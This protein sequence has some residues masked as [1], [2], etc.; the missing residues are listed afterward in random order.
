LNS[1]LLLN[2]NIIDFRKETSDLKG[3]YIL[4]N[5]FGKE[6]TRKIS[7]NFE[8]D[9]G[10]WLVYR[11][12]SAEESA[13]LKRENGDRRI[14]ILLQNYMTIEY[15]RSHASSNIDASCFYIVGQGEGLKTMAA[16]AERMSTKNV[17][18]VKTIRKKAIEST[19]K[20]ASTAIPDFMAT[21]IKLLLNPVDEFSHISRKL[22]NSNQRV[23]YR[24]FEM[25][26]FIH[27]VVFMAGTIFF[28]VVLV[29]IFWRSVSTIGVVR[30]AGIR[31]RF[32]IRHLILMEFYKAWGVLVDTSNWSEREYY[33][34][35]GV[36]VDT[37]YWIE[38]VKDKIVLNVYYRA[39][40]KFYYN[41]VHSSV[42]TLW[43]TI[44]SPAYYKVLRP[45][46]IYMSLKLEKWV[47]YKG[48]QKFYYVTYWAFGYAWEKFLSPLYFA[49][50]HRFVHS[51]LR[52]VFSFI[53]YRVLQWLFYQTFHSV[54]HNVI[55]PAFS[56]LWYE[57]LVTKIY[58]KII[59][60]G[61]N[62]TLVTLV[63]RVWP[64]V[65]LHFF[66]RIQNF[67]IFKIRHYFL[68][69]IFKSYG[70]LYDLVMFTARVTKL[71]LLYPFFKVYWFTSFQYNKRIK[72][73]FA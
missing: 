33:K 59:H 28:R 72:K 64:W 49:T 1:A 25:C 8:D 18:F 53:Y 30:V 21:L 38:R 35:Y 27:F 41:M 24:L 34:V 37:R 15:F 10:D 16:V 32:F 62:Y 50:L 68:M 3:L 6:V 14:Y 63:Y 69:A 47:Y 58:Y 73:F 67:L 48:V 39:I 57:L 70:L 23:L 31:L 20:Q 42:H 26:N 40:H 55:V 5:K 45:F 43:L 61:A 60:R 52:P 12:L 13:K 56:Y 17:L 46:F 29:Q 4:E 7:L 44:M 54:Y 65:K 36:V 22:M 66:I 2:L 9:G 51:V 11:Y 71:Y 19:E